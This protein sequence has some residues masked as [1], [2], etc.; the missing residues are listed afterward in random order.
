M[1]RKMARR[2]N[3]RYLISR[4]GV[5]VGIYPGFTSVE[6]VKRAKAQYGAGKY[7]A[8]K[9]SSDMYLGRGGEDIA[10]RE[11]IERQRQYHA[12]RLET[13]R[14][15]KT[16]PAVADIIFAQLGGNR[17]AT[18]TG[19]RSFVGSSNKLQFKIPQNKSG[20]NFVTI[21]LTPDD[22]YTVTFAKYRGLK[23]T[24]LK[25]IE[26]VYADQLRSIFESYTGLYTS[27]GTMKYTPNG[28]RRNGTHIH[29]EKI[30]HLDVAKVHNP[31][32]VFQ[33]RR[34]VFERLEDGNRIVLTLGVVQLND[35][36]TDYYVYYGGVY[37]RFDHNMLDV[38]ESYFDAAEERIIS[39]GYTITESDKAPATTPI[40]GPPWYKENPARY[41]KSNAR[42]NNPE[43]DEALIPTWAIPAI[44]YGDYSGL[45]D[46]EET[47]VRAYVAKLPAGAVIEYDGHPFFSYKNS[48]TGP[49]GGEVETA[50]IYTL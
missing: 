4:D 41:V 39:D 45:S 35:P 40:S 8:E 11:R 22:L 32:E 16:N 36:Q 10:A 5:E 23:L 1:K 20:A 17:F 25:A 42:R 33:M 37:R 49:V 13:A 34:V 47:A 21:E 28:K 9:V 31:R 48:V 15:R 3:P 6:A 43:W 38:A 29:A 26:G 46:E 7:V 27:L 24:T 19:S 50:I 12:E 2:S 14:K 18:M 44:E 30:D